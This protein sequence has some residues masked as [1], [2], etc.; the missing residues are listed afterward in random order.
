MRIYAILHVCPECL[1]AI[2]FVPN[3]DSTIPAANLQ[4]ADDGYVMRRFEVND[5]FVSS[6]LK[7]QPIS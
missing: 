2:P 3:V 5:L 7:G 1:K 6:L 4:C